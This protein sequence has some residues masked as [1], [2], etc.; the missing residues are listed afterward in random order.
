MKCC[1]VLTR[2]QALSRPAYE[3]MTYFNPL[4]PGGEERTHIDNKG[5][6]F[7]AHQSVFHQ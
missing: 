6:D 2:G 1:I 4:C 7:D 3:T 5:V